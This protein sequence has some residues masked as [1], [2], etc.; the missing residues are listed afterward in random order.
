[1]SSEPSTIFRFRDLGLGDRSGE[2][3]RRHRDLIRKG[4]FVWWGWWKI[5]HEKDPPTRMLV[6]PPKPATIYMLDTGALSEGLVLYRAQLTE[7]ALSP[8]TLEIPS[9]DISLTPVYYNQRRF[10]LWL[11]LTELCEFPEHNIHSLTIKDVPTWP[12]GDDEGRLQVLDKVI[13]SARE[14]WRSGMTTVTIWRALID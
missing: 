3:I 10:T 6:E 8:T 7:I 2:T 12:E 1:M 5:P 9:P 13:T 4:G 11:K 14:Y